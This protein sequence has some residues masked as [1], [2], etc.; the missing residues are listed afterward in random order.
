MI[1]SQQNRLDPSA[2]GAQELD[3]MAAA[4]SQ[5]GHVA[6]IDCNGNRT[7]IPEAFYQH[8]MRLV[9]LMQEGKA[10]VMMPENEAFT[11]QAAA[12]Y[13]GMSRQHFVGLL[14]SKRIPFHKVGSH[15]RVFFKDLLT[16]EKLRDAERREAL[17][18]LSRQVDAA[19]LYDSNYT[20]D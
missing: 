9:R 7:E 18:N 3:R 4:L 10:I 6:F 13:L 5:P 12:N 14:E 17:D 19:G 1:T 15:R 8:L 16:F 2:L 11:T 20:G